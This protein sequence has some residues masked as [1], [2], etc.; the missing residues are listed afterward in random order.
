MLSELL[1]VSAELRAEPQKPENRLE[2]DAELATY[3]CHVEKLRNLLPSIHN[4]LLR[5]RSRLEDQRSR[6]QSAVQ[7]ARASRQT[8]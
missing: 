4:Q 6:L 7:W 8:L 1:R 5:Q 3:R 2:L